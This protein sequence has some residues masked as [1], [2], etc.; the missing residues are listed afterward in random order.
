[1]PERAYRSAATATMTN[2]AMPTFEALSA[3]AAPMK[4]PLAGCDV[5]ATADTTAAGEDAT[6]VVWVVGV[7]GKKVEVAFR[8][9]GAQEEEGAEEVV[10]EENEV[11]VKVAICETRMVRV[12][13]WV[14]VPMVVS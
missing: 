8:E 1:M 9:I 10:E 7:A 5:V 6:R 12:R 3:G 13:V 11:K 4:L 2:P 14:E